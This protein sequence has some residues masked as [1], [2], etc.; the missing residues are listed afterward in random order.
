MPKYC[1]NQQN[2]AGLQSKINH[3]WNG[4][5][6][7]RCQRGQQ[8]TTGTDGRRVS[9]PGVSACTKRLSEEIIHVHVQN[10]HILRYV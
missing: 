4:I 3:N 7:C 5:A 10:E 6:I 2:G 8:P 9:R 1:K